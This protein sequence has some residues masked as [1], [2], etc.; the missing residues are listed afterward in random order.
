MKAINVNRIVKAGGVFTFWVAD[1]FALLN[2]KMGGDLKKI[3]VVGRYFVEVWKAAGMNLSNVKFLWASKE[4]NSRPDEYWSRVMDISRS[5]NISRIKKCC[6]IMGR[7]EGDSMPSSQMLY[8]CMQCADIFFL[9]ADICQLGLDQRKVN[10][11]ARDYCT[12][13]IKP[14]I[15]SHHMLLGMKKDQ[16]KMSKSDP[17]SAIF[18]EDSAKDVQRKINKAYCPELIVEKNPILD[19]TKHIIFPAQNNQFTVSIRLK[20]GSSIEKTYTDYNELE[21]DYASGFLFPGDLKPALIKSINRLLQPVRDHFEND[22]Y[23]KNLLETIKRWQSELT[24]LR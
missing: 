9:K 12:D 24:K 18:M 2:N 15:L 16:E 6:T 13:P 17:D 11:L 4:I 8:P 22:A 10:M 5:N 19:Y 20:D 3:Q 7:G 23:A 1:W 21:K 14:V